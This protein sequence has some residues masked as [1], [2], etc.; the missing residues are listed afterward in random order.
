MEPRPLRSHPTLGDVINAW[1]EVLLIW[2]CRWGW[3]L[4]FAFGFGIGMGIAFLYLHKF[5]IW[6]DCP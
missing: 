5:M 1:S 2:G 3:Q 6:M 4:V